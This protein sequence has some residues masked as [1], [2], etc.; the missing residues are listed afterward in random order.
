MNLCGKESEDIRCKRGK[1]F[2][3]QEAKCYHGQRECAPDVYKAIYRTCEGQRTCVVSDLTELL[4]SDACYDRVIEQSNI[5][6]DYICV[7]GRYRYLV[8]VEDVQVNVIF[9]TVAD[10]HSF[11]LPFIFLL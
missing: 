9:I 7:D 8:S 1:I 4:S 6:M 5:F 10:F 2:H 11:T 3:L